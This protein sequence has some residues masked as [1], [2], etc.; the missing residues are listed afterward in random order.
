[1]KTCITLF[2]NIYERIICTCHGCALVAHCTCPGKQNEWGRALN[3]L[4]HARA[5]RYSWLEIKMH[6][7]YKQSTITLQIWPARD[8][9][10]GDQSRPHQFPDLNLK[11]H[12]DTVAGAPFF[13]AHTIFRLFVWFLFYSRRR[14]RGS[15]ICLFKNTIAMSTEYTMFGVCTFSLCCVPPGNT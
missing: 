2:C 9:A 10:T 15:Q 5:S 13:L 8:A 6:K 7:C 11:H 14:K 4:M 12:A 3:Y 1:M